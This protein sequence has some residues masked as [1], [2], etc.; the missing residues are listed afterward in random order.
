MREESI[1][2]RLAETQVELQRVEAEYRVL[3]D[4]S[5][6]YE[7]WLAVLSM[8]THE[9]IA[10]SVMDDQ[11]QG[12]ASARTAN[13]GAGLA[14]R[15]RASSNEPG[16]A[17]AVVSTSLVG[18]DLERDSAVDAALVSV[19]IAVESSRLDELVDGESEIGPTPRGAVSVTGNDPLGS[20]NDPQPTSTGSLAER[21][22]PSSSHGRMDPTH[23]DGGSEADESNLPRWPADM[24][25]RAIDPKPRETEPVGVAI[26][27]RS[28]VASQVESRRSTSAEPVGEIGPGSDPALEPSQSTGPRSSDPGTNES[29]PSSTATKAGTDGLAELPW[30]GA[31]SAVAVSMPLTQA[32]GSSHVVRYHTDRVGITA[33][34]S[35]LGTVVAGARTRRLRR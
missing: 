23:I 30:R 32:I 22:Q 27:D 21:S 2:Q 20:T 8:P 13:S 1:R 11:A 15:A 34:L 16:D 5:R 14:S 9:A 25:S 28:G 18:S 3:L 24:W 6:D 19:M 7:R 17:T 29:L 33:I 26:S 4:L 12:P 10:G 31:G 35:L